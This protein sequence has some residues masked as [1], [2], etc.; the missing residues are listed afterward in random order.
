MKA[1]VRLLLILALVAPSFAS[2]QTTPA[3]VPTC[4]LFTSATTVNYNTKVRLDW[5]TT[6][7]TSG[8]LNEVGAIPPNGF[9]FVVPGK[10]TTYTAS[11]AGPGG[12][13]VCRV[14]IVVRAG[15]PAGGGSG[16]V[17][18][19]GTID[20]TANPID[21]NRPVNLDRPVNLNVPNV[22]L[23][24][25]QTVTPAANPAGGGGLFGSIV[26]PECRSGKTVI[27]GKTVDTAVATC[28][29]CAMGQMA[30]NIINFLLGLTIPAAALLFAWAGILFFS[31][32][33]VPEQINRAKKIFKTVVIGFVIAV[34]AWLLV[35]TVIQMLVTGTAYQDGSWK[36][37]N[38]TATR[39]LRQQQIQKTIGEYLTSSLPGL[40][41]YTPPASSHPAYS[42]TL[43]GN[44]STYSEAVGGCID[45][46]TQECAYAG[47]GVAPNAN[48]NIAGAFEGGSCPSTATYSEAAGGC[49]D[50]ETGEC[51]F[52]NC[53][54]LMYD[55]NPSRGVGG[56]C[57]AGYKYTQD[58][59]DSW[60]ENPNN[61][62]D[63]V[64]TDG[65][66][67]GSNSAATSVTTGRRGTVMCADSNPHCSVSSLQALGLDATQARTASCI[68]YTELSGQSVGCSGTGPCGVFQISQTN[69]KAYAPAGC[70]AADF[71]GDIIKAQNNGSCNART[72]AIMID[73]Q[74]WQPWTGNNP[75][76]APW[77][78]A[79]RTCVDNYDPANQT[80]LQP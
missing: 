63:W 5:T 27:N 18:G 69:W 15:T 7:V 56:A 55:S 37:L 41:S 12:T 76:Q 38:C 11:F 8:Y 36:S 13:V 9:A 19:G 30:Q 60:C 78:S 44:G 46:V 4:K 32:R 33:G 65:T 47:C 59:T 58:S 29:I 26:P 48:N 74:G 43:C 75:G 28:D 72:M 77:N 21:T 68:A 53:G 70:S 45:N 1:A 25:V 79:A 35:N 62:D 23:P 17:N 51:T 20:T 80:R 6:N 24:T 66:G 57:P 71:G 22:T 42:T 16:A 40:Q 73:D 54:V 3:P 64:D 34:S 2:A 52:Q 31:S 61:P 50:R 14:G 67:L 10:N 49:V 39:I